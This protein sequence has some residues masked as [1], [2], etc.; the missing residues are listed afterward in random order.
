VS[1][2]QCSCRVLGRNVMLLQHA[3]PLVAPAH[4]K[5]EG[6]RVAKHARQQRFTNTLQQ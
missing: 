3:A 6:K 1:T 5:Q 4:R 2:L